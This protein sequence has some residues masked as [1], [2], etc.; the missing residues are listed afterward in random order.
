MEI[1][2]ILI[3]KFLSQ[4]TNNNFVSFDNKVR[5]CEFESNHGFENFRENCKCAFYVC[6]VTFYGFKLFQNFLLVW[7]YFIFLIHKHLVINSFW[8][9]YLDHINSCMA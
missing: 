3:L 8:S 1:G 7:F 2:M 6:H 5:L 9:D 4:K